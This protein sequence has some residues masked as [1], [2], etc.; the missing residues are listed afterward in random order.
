MEG[1]PM[2]QPVDERLLDERLAALEAARP[3]SPRIVSRLEALIRA[4][5]DAL[6]FRVNPLTFASE[7]GLEQGEAID[8][9]LHAAA[10]GPVL[11]SASVCS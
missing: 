4:D 1:R 2:A 5:D 10:Q 9:F 7:R 6:L 8:L 11:P 3:W